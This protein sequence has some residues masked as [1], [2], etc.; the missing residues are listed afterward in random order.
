[1][2]AIAANFKVKV[3]D[4]E[5]WLQIAEALTRSSRSEHGTVWFGCSRSLDDQ[6][7]D[8]SKLA[9]LAVG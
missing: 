2:N 3:A 1:M 8:W 5:Q 4:V 9:E 7:H 6:R